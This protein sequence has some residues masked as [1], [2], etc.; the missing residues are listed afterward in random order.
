MLWLTTQWSRNSNVP[1]YDSLKDN[2]FIA[3]IF[4]RFVCLN[5]DCITTTMKTRLQTAELRATGNRI[6][7]AF[8][9]FPLQSRWRF[10]SL[11]VFR[12]LSPKNDFRLINM[13]QPSC[14]SWQKNNGLQIVNGE[15]QLI[16]TRDF[17]VKK[18][19]LK[20]QRIVKLKVDKYT[21]QT[22]ESHYG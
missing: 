9:I 8:L 17:F 5:K 6:R 19:F 3:I 15:N 7:D 18:L 16:L 22:Q 11:F 4:V 1:S 12:R 21:F 2:H 10:F 20:W 13:Q 14:V